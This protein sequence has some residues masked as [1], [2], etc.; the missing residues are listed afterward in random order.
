MADTVNTTVIFESNRDYVVQLSNISDATGETDVVK[1]DVSSLVGPD[2]TNAPTTIRIDE[3]SW[4]VSGMDYVLLEWDATAD[5]EAIVLAGSNS[6]DFRFAG[7]L[8]NPKS[9][10]YTGDLT[11]TTAGATATGTYNIVLACKKEA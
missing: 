9:T 7:G 2:G 4:D 6:T 8:R 5:D 11:L 10:G 3:I 1:V